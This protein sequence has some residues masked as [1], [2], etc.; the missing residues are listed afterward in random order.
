MEDFVDE[1][2]NKAGGAVEDLLD[3]LL[4][5]N[6]EWERLVRSYPMP[7]LALAIAGGF[8]LGLKHGPTIL[9]AAA[10]FVAG[11]VSRQV[12]GGLFGQRG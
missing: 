6:L 8:Y 11:E 9:T 2:L 3:E 10:T 1:G 7:A 12:G 4:P 5:E